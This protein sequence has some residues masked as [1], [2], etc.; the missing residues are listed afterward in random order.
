MIQLSVGDHLKT[1]FSGRSA[2][3]HSI[4]APQAPI[5]CSRLW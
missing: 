2:E 4:I 1:K 5:I 3:G